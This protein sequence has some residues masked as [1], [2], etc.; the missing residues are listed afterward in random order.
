MYA[1][2]A[3]RVLMEV[4]CFALFAELLWGNPYC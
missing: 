3:L 2:L 4:L 1:F